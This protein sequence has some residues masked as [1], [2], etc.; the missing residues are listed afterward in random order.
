MVVLNAAAAFIAA[1]LD[2][3]LKEGINRAI[4][5]IDSGRAREKLDKLLDF[6]LQC[7]P[8]LREA[9]GGGSYAFSLDGDSA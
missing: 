2:T 4:D 7:R 9:V 8:F 3:G 1:G 6:T 5:S